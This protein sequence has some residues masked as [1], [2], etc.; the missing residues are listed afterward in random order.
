MVFC[1]SVAILVR[2]LVIRYDM[3]K[4]KEVFNFGGINFDLVIMK[5]VGEVTVYLQNYVR[6][7][8]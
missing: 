8:F 4:Q 6:A 1:I 7:R 2:E 3:Q 5:A